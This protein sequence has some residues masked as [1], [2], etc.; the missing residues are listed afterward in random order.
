MNQYEVKDREN[1]MCKQ[2]NIVTR[3]QI[4]IVT[5]TSEIISIRLFLM[6]YRLGGGGHLQSPSAVFFSAN[7]LAL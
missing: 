3:K 7:N 1:V 6:N 2:L 4:T 5:I